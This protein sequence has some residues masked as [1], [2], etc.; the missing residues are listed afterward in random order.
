MEQLLEMLMGQQNKSNLSDIMGQFGLDEAQAQ[1]AIGALL[2]SVTKGIQEQASV[3]NDA[4][5][6][7]IAEAKQQAYLDD[8]NQHL[9]EPEAVEN[10][11]QI[12]GQILG[13]KDVSRQVASQAAEQT[14]LDSGILKKL[15]PMVASMAMGAMGKQAS[16][17]GLQQNPNGVMDLIGSMLGGDKND[18]GFGLDDVLSIAS[19]FLR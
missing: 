16:S 11:N 13:S 9:Y 12:L 7:E 5:L 6:A 1:R 3:K 15:L 17:Q 18:D 14:G 19:K 2:P 10:G 8:D 4:I